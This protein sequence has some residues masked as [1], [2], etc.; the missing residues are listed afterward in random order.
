MSKLKQSVLLMFYV[1]TSLSV[2]DV[3][4]LNFSQLGGCSISNP[5]TVWWMLYI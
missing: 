1:E 4:Y 3:L 5:D 2:I